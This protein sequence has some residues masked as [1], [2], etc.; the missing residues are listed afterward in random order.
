M[1][2]GA[3]AGPFINWT[4]SFCYFYSFL[5]GFHCFPSLLSLTS[6]WCRSWK[7]E[8]CRSACCCRAEKPVH[9]CNSSTQ[10]HRDFHNSEYHYLKTSSEARGPGWALKLSVL[11]SLLTLTGRT[12]GPKRAKAVLSTSRVITAENILAA[13][14]QVKSLLSVLYMY[15]NFLLKYLHHKT[16]CVVKGSNV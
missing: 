2:E 9:Q 3:L 15:L 6:C 13:Y 14:L 11:L 16:L 10:Q 1:L 8:S 5:P 7:P 12:V 4:L